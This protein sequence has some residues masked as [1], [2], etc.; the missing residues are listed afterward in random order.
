MIRQTGNLSGNKSSVPHLQVC[1]AYFPFHLASLL[2][3]NN[4]WFFSL[5]ENS[6]HS[7]HSF[8]LPFLSSTISGVSQD[9]LILWARCICLIYVPSI[10]LSS[11]QELQA[12][13]FTE[14]FLYFSQGML[15]ISGS[16]IHS[17]CIESVT[18]DLQID[19]NRM[20]KKIQSLYYHSFFILIAI[21]V[22]S[23]LLW[24]PPMLEL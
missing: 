19:W 15:H 20:K 7:S 16:G 8:S 12:D 17:T 14:A 2:F 21:F 6:P 3:N 22:F 24:L 11:F 13:E 4:V 1:N 23:L 10:S 9:L 5:T 18:E